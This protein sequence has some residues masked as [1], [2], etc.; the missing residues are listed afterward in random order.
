MKTLMVLLL[1]VFG[2]IFAQESFPVTVTDDMGRNVTF[3]SVPERIVVV[4]EE[5]LEVLITLGVQPVGYS[6]RIEA[7]TG[8][9][10]T[11]H[12]Y[13]P[14]KVLGIPTYLGTGEELSLERVVSL[15]PDLIL[16]PSDGGAEGSI[17]DSLAAIAPALAFD[18]QARGAWQRVAVKL[19]AVFGKETRAAEAVSSFETET[20]VL[21]ADLS[22]VVN[23][24]PRAAVLYLPASTST[25]VLGRDF[26]LGGLV[27]ALGFDT[28]KPAGLDLGPS[29]AA[30]ISLEAL[31]NLETDTVFTIQFSEGVQE[32]FQVETFLA[33]MGVPVVRVVLEPNRPYT[34]AISERFYLEQ[35]HDGVLS[36][37]GESAASQ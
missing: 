32:S 5:L 28:V 37:Y 10:V 36:A 2:V 18:L 16:F 11:E 33:S 30:E 26:A 24:A 14:Q 27:E 8:D 17:L 1:F 9:L 20:D 23:E 12:P 6:G 31:A 13:L 21:R 29:G 7:P 3:G 15:K 34:G 25:F 35:I 4:R 22:G 19:G